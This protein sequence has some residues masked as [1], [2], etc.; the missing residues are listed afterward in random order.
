M[1]P[2]FGWKKRVQLEL[3]MLQLPGP[4]LTP[5]RVW[6][7]VWHQL[8]LPSQLAAQRSGC[9]HM[10]IPRLQKSRLAGMTKKRSEDLFPARV[11][12][13]FGPKWGFTGDD[14]RYASG[15]STAPFIW[16]HLLWLKEAPRVLAGDGTPGMNSQVICDSTQFQQHLFKNWN[17]GI[18]HTSLLSWVES[19]WSKH[20]AIN[21]ID[22]YKSII[23][24]Q[25]INTYFL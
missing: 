3:E 23:C 19:V 16:E 14:S 8:C 15:L 9:V 21:D 24:P 10:H 11:L 7:D 25:Y 22:F 6:A 5:S 2:C 20:L 1:L 13:S 12:D 18:H 17:K 4:A